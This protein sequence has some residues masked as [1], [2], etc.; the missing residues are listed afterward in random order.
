MKQKIIAAFNELPLDARAAFYSNYLCLIH[1]AD[2]DPDVIPGLI[3]QAPKQLIERF[4]AAMDVALGKIKDAKL[5][6]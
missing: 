1:A 5:K 3:E 2:N 4:G 6:P